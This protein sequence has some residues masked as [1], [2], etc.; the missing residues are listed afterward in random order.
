M[1]RSQ[2][3]NEIFNERDTVT[4]P[5]KI[6]SSILHQTI[7]ASK[8][9][10]FIKADYVMLLVQRR[11]HF[12]VLEWQHGYVRYCR[13]PSGT[14]Q[15]AV[16]AYAVHTVRATASTMMPMITLRY[17]KDTLFERTV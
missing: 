14:V 13:A 15:V 9:S 5:L 7:K 10:G 12:Y 6:L 17:A 2:V 1:D 3:E 16:S 8:K 11:A 4:T